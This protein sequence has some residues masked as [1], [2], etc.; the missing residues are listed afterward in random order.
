MQFSSEN[1]C[2]SRALADL[3]L[4]T[5]QVRPAAALIATLKIALFTGSTTPGPDSVYADFTEANF[6]GYAR[7][8]VTNP[9]PIVAPSSLDV[10]ILCQALFVATTATPFVPNTVTGYF[11]TDG[12]TGYYGGERFTTPFPVAIAG[13]FIAIDAT[14]LMSL[15]PSVQ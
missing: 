14:L 9:A 13:D 5:V 10:G 8:T 2:W 6:S 12:T 1:L 11:L 3:V 15:V 7:A 4:A